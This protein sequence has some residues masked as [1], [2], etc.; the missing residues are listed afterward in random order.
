MLHVLCTGPL[1]PKHDYQG[2]RLGMNVS[3]DFAFRGFDR[4][5]RS[6]TKVGGN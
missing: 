2:F 4:R 3:E 6:L 1:C 5:V